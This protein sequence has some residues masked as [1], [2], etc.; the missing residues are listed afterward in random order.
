MSKKPKTRRTEK[1]MK[2]FERMEK[3]EA[4]RESAR[5]EKRRKSLSHWRKQLQHIR[6]LHPNLTY[7]EQL[8]KASNAYKIVK[9]CKKS[10]ASMLKIT[11]SKNYNLCRT[12]FS[13]EQIMKM[14][15][16]GLKKSKN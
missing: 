2:K 16:K 13:D 3:E 5:K 11:K 8:K 12:R 1:L 15:S 4:K 6:K 14:V 7:K 9:G 10:K